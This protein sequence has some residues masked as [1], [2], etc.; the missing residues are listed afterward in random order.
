[1]EVIALSPSYLLRADKRDAEKRENKHSPVV[2][3]FSL[4]W[5]LITQVL[6]SHLY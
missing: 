4:L 1:M 5:R 3:D 6:A 2:L